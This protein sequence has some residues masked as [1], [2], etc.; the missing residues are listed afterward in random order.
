M[1]VF[2]EPGEEIDEAPRWADVDIGEIAVL[3][4]SIWERLYELIDTKCQAEDAE[5][6]RAATN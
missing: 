3:P 5:R 2:T 4:Q 6:R 1:E